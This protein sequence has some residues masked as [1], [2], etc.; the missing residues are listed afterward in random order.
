MSR[1]R[2][3]RAT[4]TWCL[5]NDPSSA[6]GQS[7]LPATASFSIQTSVGIRSSDLGVQGRFG[8]RVLI[9]HFD[10]ARRGVNL[11]TLED[12]RAA[13]LPE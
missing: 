6:F 9:Q 13:G 12:D 7:Q 1:S 8:H 4:A 10:R 3:T 11:S 5:Q 2:Q